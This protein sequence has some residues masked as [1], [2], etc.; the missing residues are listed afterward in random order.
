VRVCVCVCACV[1]VF[2]CL[3]V[4]IWHVCVYLCVYGER[5]GFCECFYAGA[6]SLR[7]SGG[8]PCFVSVSGAQWSWKFVTTISRP[9]DTQALGSAPESATLF[10]T[11][12]FV[13]PTI[14]PDSAE[15]QHVDC[16]AAEEQRCALSGR[17]CLFFLSLFS[18]RYVRCSRHAHIAA[19]MSI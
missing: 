4:F 14:F 17:Y 3:P 16:E 11:L 10:D 2:A 19:L 6:T 12:H 18:E 1:C 15:W 7:K 5:V 8:N 13:A 9:I